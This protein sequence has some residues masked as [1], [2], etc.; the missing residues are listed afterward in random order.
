MWTC[1]NCGISGI[2]DAARRCP[3][4]G[5]PR[6]ME[7]VL[8]GSVGSLTLRTDLV[9]GCRNL[10]ELIGEDARYAECEQFRLTYKDGEWFAASIGSSIRNPCLL[11]EAILATSPV[12]L[13][14]GDRIA[15]TSRSNH[16]V[17]KGEIRV[18]FG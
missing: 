11:N 13:A 6:F 17:R 8:T 10:T 9:F 4:C 16:S 1:D 7:L 14:D 5:H 2:D 18:S 3:G 12:R 15:I